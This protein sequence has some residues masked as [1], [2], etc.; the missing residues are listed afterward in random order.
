MPIVSTIGSDNVELSWT[1]SGHELDYYQIR[2]KSKNEKDI[3]KYLTTDRNKITIT[4]LMAA[5]SYVFQVRAVFKDQEG[6]Y[7]P[8]SNEVITSES[9]A[10][11]LRKT[12]KLVKEGNPS[13]YRLKGTKLKHSR[14]PL[15]KTRK[16]EFGKTF[17]ELCIINR[18]IRLKTR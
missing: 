13:I 17:F 3:W 10:T 4:G 1:E 15:A 7:G 2:Y 9:S 12:S 16:F 6:K 5:T 11:K 18:F 14:N 8:Q